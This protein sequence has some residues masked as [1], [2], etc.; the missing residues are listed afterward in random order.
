[1][2]ILSIA[3]M[4]IFSSTA[5]AE[6]VPLVEGDISNGLADQIN[7][8]NGKLFKLTAISDPGAIMCYRAGVRGNKTASTYAFILVK[9]KKFSDEYSDAYQ[10]FIDSNM[11]PS[12]AQL[13]MLSTLDGNEKALENHKYLVRAP[14]A[15]FFCDQLLSKNPEEKKI[16]NSIIKRMRGSE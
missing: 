7:Q 3:A 13:K 8:A 11:S 9:S 2:K 6:S 5:I 4:L 1:M 10:R 14:V 12:E 16:I 15:A